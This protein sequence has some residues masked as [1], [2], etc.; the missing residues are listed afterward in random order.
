[1]SPGAHFIWKLV[2]IHMQMKTNF[3][4]KGWAPG[5]ALEKRPKVMWKLSIH[6]P[7]ASHLGHK[8]EWNKPGPFLIVWPWNVV[9]KKLLLMNRFILVPTNLYSFF[10]A[11]EPHE[12]DQ[13]QKVVGLVGLFVLHFQIYRGLDKKFFTKLWDL[14]KKVTTCGY[15]CTVVQ[16]FCKTTPGVPLVQRNTDWFLPVFWSYVLMLEIHSVVHLD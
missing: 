11:D 15:L 14:H 2:F 8:L 3:H 10:I 16:R 6:G 7:P 5:R 1:M 13:R 9:S 4:L 12:V